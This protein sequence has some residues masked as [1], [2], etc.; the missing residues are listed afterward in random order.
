MR[1]RLIALSGLICLW[2]GLGYGLSLITRRVA[3]WFV[4]TDELLY[5]R[6][7]ISVARTHSP[8]P[9]VHT[10]LISNLNQLYPL[11]IAATFR[12]R[13]VG[14]LQG[15]HDAHILNAFVMTSTV[16]PVY[17]LAR[18][19]T[20]NSWLPFVVATASVCVP[21]LTLSSFLLSEVV[22]YPAFALALLALH[23]TVAKPSIR[24]D[25]LAGAAILLAVL[26]RAQFYS[27]AVAL[28][29]AIVL[30]GLVDRR[31]RETLR[32]HA[33]LAGLYL[34]GVIAALLALLTGHHVLGTYAET[35]TGNP[36]PPHIVDS[37]FAHIA[38]VALAGGLLPFV[39]GG[40]WIAANLRRS[41]STERHAFAWVAV[42]TIV[43]LA[44][45]VASFDLRFGGG[46]VRDRYLFYLT[47][48]IMVAFAAGLTASRAPRW[49]LLAP[50]VVL[51]IGFSWAP[52]PVFE[53][54]NADTPA[55]VIDNWLLGELNGVGG[56]RLFLV[57][58]A[59]LVAAAFVE[60]TVFL[61]RTLVA[62]GACVLLLVALPAETGYAFKRLFAVNG[63]SGLPMTLDQ[64][65][66]FG[67]V[68]REITPTSEAVMVPYPVIRGDYF[69]NEGFWWDLEF[70]NRSVDREA[71][72][73][74]QFSVTPPGTFPKTDPQFDPRT[75]LANFDLDSY[76][77]Q[78]TTDA[79]FHI[80]G[81][82]LSSQRGVS[83]VFPYRPWRADWVSY[84]LYPD[85]WTRP[86]QIARFRVFAEPKQT[87]PLL[88]TIHFT[89][90]VPGFE[91]R[92]VRLASNAGAAS[93]DMTGT[94]QMTTTVCVP[95]HAPADVKLT[96][97]G[98]SPVEGDPSTL[99]TLAEP[100]SAGVL[101][102]DVALD[103]PNAA[104]TCSPS[105]GT[106]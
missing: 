89:L 11:V 46:L 78:A 90:F 76:V 80:A 32:A 13:D 30:R 79:R 88:R 97:I 55:S 33:T 71:A 50:I 98:S 68:D 96:A 72:R 61:P 69:A 54:L 15:F 60:A 14:V 95:A 4:M 64:S 101:V 22:A 44:V 105:R 62:A 18:R 70:W 100:R 39:V 36:L 66:V 93:S 52:L 48:V 9:H 99:T 84:G 67:W 83:V 74:D 28:A 26:A 53:K 82:V 19:V 37:A 24:N 41:E 77:A 85:G 2:L 87:R 86:G 47:P 104:A 34:V 59:A 21:W 75:G 7:A 56:T 1:S 65:V 25:G 17:F 58:A 20:H 3:D 12:S 92:S 29:A 6:L 103:P 106:R 49:S 8:L 27:L 16:F 5:E 23:A 35:S 45:E 81:R 40:A 38:I 51:V 73:P 31:L 57:V 42:A 94:Q 10:E 63:T 43:A 102:G 91:T